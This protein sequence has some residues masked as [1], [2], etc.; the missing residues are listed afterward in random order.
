MG[1]Q[2]NGIEDKTSG[3]AGRIDYARVVSS[4]CGISG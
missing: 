2:R 4:G 3:V 1:D